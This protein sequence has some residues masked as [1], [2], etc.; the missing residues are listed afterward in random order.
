MFLASAGGRTGVP[1]IVIVATDGYATV[2]TT[3]T[4]PAA[5]ACWAL[6]IRV[7]VIGMTSA[8]DEQQLSAISSPPHT[9]SQNYW[10]TPDYTTLSTVLAGVQ[11]S[12]C[13][14]PKP[15]LPGEFQKSVVALRQ[16]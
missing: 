6:G 16:R 1:H 9:A 7:F 13:T 15:N 4:I 10:T 2:N 5:Q 14:P 11:N 8:I 3:D 12:T